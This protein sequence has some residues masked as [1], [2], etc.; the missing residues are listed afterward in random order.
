MLQ[1]RMEKDCGHTVSVY[2]GGKICEIIFPNPIKHSL[3][4]AYKCQRLMVSNFLCTLRCWPWKDLNRSLFSPICLQP[5]N[6]ISVGGQ[7]VKQELD[8]L[9]YQ[10]NQDGIGSIRRT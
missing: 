1:N 2:R 10:Q 8:I 4:F 9:R 7:A 6:Q 3:K 5:V